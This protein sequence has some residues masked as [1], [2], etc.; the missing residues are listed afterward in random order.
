MAAAGKTIRA[1]HIERKTS[2]EQPKLCG[3]QDS[4]ITSNF[5]S[6]E[7]SSETSEKAIVCNIVKLMVLQ[8]LSCA[9]AC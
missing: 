5:P 2:I 3:K 6:K 1:L 8:A 9:L 7:N 4:I